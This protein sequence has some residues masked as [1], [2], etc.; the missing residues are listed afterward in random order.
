MSP[1]SLSNLNAAKKLKDSVDQRR[2]EWKKR[3]P[4]TYAAVSVLLARNKDDLQGLSAAVTE[5][6]Q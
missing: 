3:I 1:T 5:H 6:I 2:N 4:D